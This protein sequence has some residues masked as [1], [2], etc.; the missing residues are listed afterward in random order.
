MAKP[1]PVLAALG[2]NVRKRREAL[3]YLQEVLAEKVE[4]DQR[5]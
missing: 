1:H 4:L 2:R 3:D 5:P